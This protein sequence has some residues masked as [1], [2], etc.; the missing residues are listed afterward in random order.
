MMKQ[1]MKNKSRFLQKE[2]QLSRIAELF[3]KKNLRPSEVLV[4]L[5]IDRKSVV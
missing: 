3:S 5:L 1:Y 2:E 4:F